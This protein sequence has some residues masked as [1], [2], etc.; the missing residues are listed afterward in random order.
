MRDYRDLAA[1]LN[2]DEGNLSA[3]RN[4]GQRLSLLDFD[5]FVDLSKNDTV[6]AV[7]N[8]KLLDFADKVDA[9]STAFSDGHL[10]CL[11]KLKIEKNV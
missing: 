2:L 1:V 5:T 7:L 11:W 6:I 8:D 10:L 4:Q 9:T 3:T